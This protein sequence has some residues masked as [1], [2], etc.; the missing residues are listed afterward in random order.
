MKARTPATIGALAR[1]YVTGRASTGEIARETARTSRYILAGFAAA[2]GDGPA[3]SLDRAGID[4]YLVA[5]RSMAPSTRRTR[6][7]VVCC[8]CRW[9]TMTGR[10]HTDPTV[11]VRPPKVPRPSYRALESP[12]SAALLAA[13][14]NVTERLVVTLGLQLGLRRA[15]IAGLELADV[16]MTDGT[17]LV[18]MGKGGHHR[19]V[20]L[21]VE[22]RSAV[23]AYLASRPSQ[24]G[25][26]L[27]CYKYPS[28]G[29]TPA[30]VGRLVNTVAYRAGVKQRARDGVGCHSLRH[31]AA[32]D[33]YRRTRDV[34]LVRDMLGHQSLSTTQVYVRSLDVE[35]LR[36]GMEGR[37]YRAAPLRSVA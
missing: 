20:P 26:L 19:L 22:C 4:R 32:S 27:R 18:R 2:V 5:I 10:V 25:P 6:Y 28:C 16:A 21:T 29:V 33:V 3:R 24:G 35:G 34:M 30:W 31:T 13:C 17:V 23:A 7:S 15:E 12:D 8:F 9:L 36:E 14:V 37:S 11:G 1:V